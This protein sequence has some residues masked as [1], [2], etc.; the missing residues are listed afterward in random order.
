MEKCKL[1][2]LVAKIGSFSVHVFANKLHLHFIWQRLQPKNVIMNSTQDWFMMTG[3]L[4]INLRNTKT[5]DAFLLNSKNKGKKPV[6]DNNQNQLKSHVQ[7][8]CRE[9]FETPNLSIA[10]SDQVPTEPDQTND[11]LSTQIDTN[12]KTELNCH[13][14]SIQDK[15]TITS[16]QKSNSSS[17]NS[18]GIAEEDLSNSQSFTDTMSISSPSKPSM[19]D[20]Y[21]TTNTK[22]SNEDI[23]FYENYDDKHSDSCYENI[24]DCRFMS[25]SEESNLYN[26]IE[27]SHSFDNISLDSDNGSLCYNNFSL[28]KNQCID[29]PSASRLAKRLYNLEGF[30]KSDV[31]CHLSKNNEFSRAVAEKYLNLFDFTGKSLDLALRVFLTQFYLIGETQD[32]ERVLVYFSK[33]FNE[34]NPNQNFKSID[35]IH[36]LTCALMLLNTDLHEE[37]SVKLL[38]CCLLLTFFPYLIFRIFRE[39]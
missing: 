9:E 25:K 15:N 8:G 18:S 2:R 7:E 29:V 4:I 6:L 1:H 38:Y 10:N 36:T 35:S 23:Y 21:T 11:D 17:G 20:N 34:C 39:K 12:T 31:A 24:R 13:D 33:R 26:M 14:L 27:D 19:S 37:V 5:G 28:L 32:R 16:S 3:D 22:Y 30:N